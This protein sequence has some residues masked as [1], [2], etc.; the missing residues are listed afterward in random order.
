MARLL[1]ALLFPAICVCWV[2]KSSRNPSLNSVKNIHHFAGPQGPCGASTSTCTR[3][4]V[5][6]TD[7]SYGGWGPYADDEDDFEVQHDEERLSDEELEATLESWDNKIAAFNSVHLVGRVGQDP[8]ARHFDDGK[9]VVN[10][11][12]AC[13]RKYHSLERKEL[14][15]PW[16]DEE[17]DWYGLEVS[18]S[19]ASK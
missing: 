5:G 10:L 9:V 15:L 17:T 18:S 4:F 13:T 16:G 3:M 14:N 1:F 12:L 19:Q 6:M 2:N 7:E 8:E 11:S